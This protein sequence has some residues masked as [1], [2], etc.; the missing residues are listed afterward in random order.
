ML[1]RHG[2]VGDRERNESGAE[3]EPREHPMK[4]SAARP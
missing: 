2:R 4:V 1:H 3:G